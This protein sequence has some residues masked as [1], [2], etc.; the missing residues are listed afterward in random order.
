[1]ISIT[2]QEEAAAIDEANI[3]K[4]DL[5]AIINLLLNLVN[6]SDSSK[7]RRLKQK[8]FSQLQEI[9]QS[10]RDLHNEQ[11]GLEDEVKLEN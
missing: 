2:A 10:I 4:Q 3:L 1:L 6:I 5:I 8:N 11:D 7:Y 9:I